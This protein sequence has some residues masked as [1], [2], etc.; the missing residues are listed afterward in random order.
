MTLEIFGSKRKSLI[1]FSLILAS[2]VV[3]LF[4]F[5][6]I[7]NVYVMYLIVAMT[8][9]SLYALLC[10]LIQKWK[11]NFMRPAAWIF[12]VSGIILR[13]SLLASEPTGSD[14]IYRYI[15]D[16]KVQVNGF[17]PY[18]YAPNDPALGHLRSSMLPVKINFPNM[19]TLYPPFAEQV[20]RVTYQIGGEHV[21][22]FKVPLFLSECA[23]M[24][25]F[26]FLLRR[27]KQS[28]ALVG[29]YALCPLPIMQFMIDGHIDALGIPF[30]VL[31]LLFWFRKKKI[32]AL[33]LY[34]FS[35][36]AKLFPIII[37]P[38]LFGE[39]RKER[40]VYLLAIPLVML[41]ASYLP[42][43]IAGSSP[44][45][46]L[47][48]FGSNWA[49][50]GS[51]FH[52]VY[53]ITNNN[54]ISRIILTAVFICVV[55]YLM[56]SKL[57]ISGKLYYTIFLFF[58]F[59]STIHP[60]YVTWLAVFLPFYFRWSGIAFVS[61]VNIS[62]IVVI[63]YHTTGKWYEPAWLPFAEY[64][65]IVLLLFR[66]ILRDKKIIPAPAS[67]GGILKN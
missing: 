67:P 39:E 58:L 6:N 52:L 59:C 20:F 56:R 34:G 63:S 50:N 12:F 13:L 36:L 30:L 4:V 2:E 35:V 42:Y 37:L 47:M 10:A 29:L 46:S 27:L 8:S 25:V 21:A 22:A 41:A 33:L 11:H 23:T 26:I 32:S 5:T 19:K 62:F 40:T 38:V 18:L 51:V 49:F 3:Y 16:G 53:F 43:M 64:V 55:A 57:H 45:E 66:E 61:L 44:F 48:L 65:P 31:F 28:E 15:W 1:I 14:D 60:W 7:M 54:Q 17:D 24:L 9:S